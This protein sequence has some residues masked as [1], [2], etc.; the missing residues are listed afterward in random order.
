MAEF[1]F[2]ELDSPVYPS[3][4]ESQ[5]EELTQGIMAIW[6][7]V[8]NHNGDLRRLLLNCQIPVSAAEGSAHI[9]L[10]SESYCAGF[11][12]YCIALR[13]QKQPGSVVTALTVP[14]FVKTAW[15]I[16]FLVTWPQIVADPVVF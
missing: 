13:A 15:W 14:G 4:L 3:I 5:Q 10:A 11:D 8:I 16:L 6:T 9:D 7:N 12:H 2:P 1:L